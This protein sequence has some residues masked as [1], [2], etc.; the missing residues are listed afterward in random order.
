VH[1]FRR[2]LQLDGCEYGSCPP[3]ILPR[4][5]TADLRRHHLMD[6]KEAIDQ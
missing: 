3:K 1:E 6:D 4:L 2:A 5:T